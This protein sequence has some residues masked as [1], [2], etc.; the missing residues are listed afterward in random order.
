M[1]G[2]SWDT[3]D[4]FENL[5][6]SSMLCFSLDFFR[7]A[8]EARNKIRSETRAHIFQAKINVFIKSRKVEKVGME[9]MG[10]KHW[11]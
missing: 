4:L 1:V 5:A 10:K 6:P 11:F 9:V 2:L 3:I 7:V 8:T